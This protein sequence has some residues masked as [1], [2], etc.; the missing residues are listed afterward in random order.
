MSCCF[1]RCLQVLPAPETVSS[2]RHHD[3]LTEFR[4]A[5]A[6][7]LLQ[8]SPRHP[9]GAAVFY[10]T[11]EVPAMTLGADSAAAGAPPGL[12]ATVAGEPPPLAPEGAA[13]DVNQGSWWLAAAW[14]LLALAGGGGALAA[15]L[16]STGR[17]RLAGLTV[18]GLVGFL[19]TVRVV[20]QAW[21]LY[22]DQEATRAQMAALTAQMQQ[23]ALSGAMGMP[24]GGFPGGGPPDEVMPGWADVEPPPPG[25]PQVPGVTMTGPAAG[26]I[27]P[28]VSLL[29]KDYWI[30]LCCW[31]CCILASKI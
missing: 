30:I 6:G 24:G 25:I 12:D 4:G 21:W 20:R 13:T 1:G 3:S 15:Q 8:V 22:C 17:A 28:P 26:P 16:G 23:L 29:L 11:P 31:F 27:G 19:A 7:T 2:S 14:G 9:R 5:S 18:F 10:Q